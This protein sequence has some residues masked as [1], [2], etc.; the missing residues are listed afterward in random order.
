FQE[1]LS[2]KKYTAQST[3]HIGC[4]TTI[5]NSVYGA[6]NAVDRL[7]N[8]CTRTE[9]ISPGHTNTVWWYVDLGDVYN[10]YEVSIIFKTYEG[11][12]SR[13]RGRFAGFSLYLSNSTNIKEGTLCYKNNDEIPTLEFSTTCIGH[14]RY[15][16][17]YNERLGGITYPEGYENLSYTEL[18]EFIVLGC[19]RLDMYGEKC[20]LKCPK[21]CQQKSCDIVNGSCHFCNPGWT[22]EFCD[23]ECTHETF[24]LNCRHNCSGHCLE[25]I[26]CNHVTGYCDKGCASG[27]TGKYCEISCDDGKYGPDCAFNCSGNCKNNYQCNKET[28]HCDVGCYP[29]YIG[30]GC[31]EL[32]SAGTFGEDCLKLCSSNCQYN[33]TCSPFNG[34]CMNGC[35]PGY[36]GSRCGTI[37][38]DG[39]FGFNC[40][41]VC[42]PYCIDICGYADGKC[43]CMPGFKGSPS[44]A[45]A[46]SEGSFGINCQYK[47][48]GH[49][50]G[51]ETCS[52]YDGSCS[53]GCKEPYSGLACDVKCDTSTTTSTVG[54]AIVIGILCI[55]LIAVSFIFF[56]QRLSFVIRV[57]GRKLILKTAI[58]EN[59]PPKREDEKPDY[60]ELEA[61][62]NTPS[63]DTLTKS[64]NSRYFLKKC[65]DVKEKLSKSTLKDNR[66][67]KHSP[68]PQ[69]EDE[70]PKY[71][72]LDAA[73]DMPSYENFPV[74]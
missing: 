33:E 39:S 34:E 13:Q 58:I 18:C 48:S 21:N 1:D 4:K 30:K 70:I 36:N 50:V 72:E 25:G 71:L 27:W 64:K 15:V 42:S 26:S 54:F 14:A 38:P 37:C 49:C 74:S 44:C 3:T 20:E 17:F 8:T 16:F 60:F 5:C 68:P 47:C 55:A 7:N 12:E 40:S 56:R 67:V 51:N 59:S 45:T 2:F 22:G 46:C 31:T 63:Y 35:A 41:N 10:I 29:G 23:I 28:G 66:F 69:K 53:R 11:W 6:P 57:K 73:S 52:R 9:P 61:S 43:R 65:F 32:C 24:G 19:A 62:G